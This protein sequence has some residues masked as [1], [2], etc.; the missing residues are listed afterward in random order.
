MNWLFFC[1][2]SF[3]HLFLFPLSSSSP[4]PP[5][6]F[7]P[8][9]LYALLGCLIYPDAALN[10]LLCL[11][12]IPPALLS[13]FSISCTHSCFYRLLLLLSYLLVL[14]PGSRSE[15]DIQPWLQQLPHQSRLLSFSIIG[16]L[17]PSHPESH[18]ESWLPVTCKV[19]Q[20]HEL[21]HTQFFILSPPAGSP[22]L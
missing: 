4:H 3:S 15:T 13:D 12:P 2:A 1:T 14:R 19:G 7:L 6:L 22:T 10:I 8:G 16:P 21:G 18:R 20:M 11:Y 9:I 17:V 5:L